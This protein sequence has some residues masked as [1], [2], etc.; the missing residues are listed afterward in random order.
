MTLI[1]RNRE[2]VEDDWLV[3]AANPAGGLP[4]P[5]A[6]PA[7][8]VI[9]PLAYWKDAGETLRGL[10]DK[11]ELGIWLAPDDEPADVV[12]EFEAIALLAVD[13]PVFRDG[14]SMSTAR[15]L[16]E[17]HG[18][19]GEIRAIGDVQRD[20]IGYM[21]RCGIDVFAVRA[22]KDIHDAL[23]AF[24]ELTLHYQGA[25]DDP[26]PLFRQVAR[27]SAAEIA[28]NSIGGDAATLADIAR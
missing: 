27:P 11:G 4:L 19:T 24:D 12:P 9:V 26:R 20:Q 18:W 3:I 13:F 22:D 23:K 25:V 16:R 21:A 7:G 2:V 15:L 10:R 6:L 17:R 14:R 1:I 28:T 8:K 5:E